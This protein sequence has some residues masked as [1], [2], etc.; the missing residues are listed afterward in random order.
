LEEIENLRKTDKTFLPEMEKNETETLCKGWQNAV[1]KS[2][3]N[4]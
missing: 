1:A 2:R 4:P 3:Y